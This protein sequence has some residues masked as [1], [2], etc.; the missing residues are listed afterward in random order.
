MRRVNG[1]G[2][3]QQLILVLETTWGLVR[4]AGPPKGTEHGSEAFGRVE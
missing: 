2:V 4:A 1:R 3:P